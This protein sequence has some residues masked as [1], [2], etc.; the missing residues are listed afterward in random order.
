MAKRIPRTKTWTLAETVAKGIA[1][2]RWRALLKNRLGKRNPFTIRA[3]YS[4]ADMSIESELRIADDMRAMVTAQARR[5]HDDHLARRETFADLLDVIE[6]F[7][8]DRKLAKVI[9][10][11]APDTGAEEV[12]QQF[13]RDHTVEPA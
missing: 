9:A 6:K 4:R 1:G 7:E 13:F 12:I 8:T 5:E 10:A 11:R 3:V 2:W